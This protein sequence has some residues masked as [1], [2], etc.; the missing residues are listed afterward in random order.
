[1]FARKTWQTRSMI[2]GSIAECTLSSSLDLPQFLQSA[3]WEVW[4]YLWFYCLSRKKEL[5]G[6]MIFLTGFPGTFSTETRSI[7]RSWT[8][9][10]SVFLV[11]LYIVSLLFVRP[12]IA[13]S[14]ASWLTSSHQRATPSTINWRSLYKGTRLPNQDH[15]ISV[16]HNGRDTP[17]PATGI[18]CG[19]PNCYDERHQRRR[20]LS[21]INNHQFCNEKVL[22]ACANLEWAVKAYG[23]LVTFLQSFSLR[24]VLWIAAL[25]T[26]PSIVHFFSS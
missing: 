12:Q 10:F 13:T 19:S 20:C 5:V 21:R 22:G 1:M 4:C 3:Q 9:Q 11:S 26:A 23:T 15:D 7:L 24:N 2:V 17:Q 25:I 6:M 14:C 18:V 16:L 8:L